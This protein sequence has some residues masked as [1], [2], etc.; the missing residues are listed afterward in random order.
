MLK[1]ISPLLVIQVIAGIFLLALPFLLFSGQDRQLDWDRA[2]LLKSLIF[3]AI[4]FSIY[5]LHSYLLLPKLYSQKKYLLYFIC[6]FALLI[7]VIVASPFDRLIARAHQPPPPPKSAYT[8]P[9][10]P[11]NPPHKDDR[12]PLL[13]VVSIFLFLLVAILGFAKETNKQLDLTMKRALQ[14]EAEKAQAELSFLKAQVNPHFL[15]NILNNIYTLA[16]IKDDNTGPSI[17]KLSNL[18]RYITDEA[19]DDFVSLEKEVSCITDYIA[20]QELRL[21]QKTSISYELLGNLEQKRI[22]PLILMAFVE[23]LFKYG[24]SNH[25]SSQ[26]SIRLLTQDNVLNFCCENTVHQDK[27]VIKRTG[28]GLENT[29][30]R[31]QH[32]YPERHILAIANDGCSFKVNLTIYL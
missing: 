19:G 28:I 7:G 13:D 4:F 14:A 10:Q 11:F 27:K 32:I 23:N 20:L 18:M 9:K 30:K 6:L 15:F 16:I 29:K 24:V 17:M 2:T 12:R 25:K 21:T 22:A 5:F 8:T 3:C 1:K 26:L 31:L